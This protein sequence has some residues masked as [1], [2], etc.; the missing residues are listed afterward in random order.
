MSL[1]PSDANVP[2][3]PENLAMMATRSRKAS[4]TVIS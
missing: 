4:A 3:A 2:T 1:V